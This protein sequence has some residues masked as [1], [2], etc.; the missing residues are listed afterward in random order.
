MS[1]DDPEVTW[2][3][4]IDESI[5]ATR[6]V[7]EGGDTLGMPGII[8]LQESGLRISPR[9]AAQ[10]ATL[11]RSVLT[12]LFCFGAML[13]SPKSTMKSAL[14]TTQSAAHQFQAVNKNFDT[15]CNDMLHRV[16]S[17]AKEANESYTFKE[18]LQQDDWNQFV[19]A[20]TKEIGDH[21]KRKH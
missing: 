18:M 1:A 4:V 13:I 2:G 8:N 21:T 9:I 16:F 17:V 5:P 20:M 12:T 14:T 11:Q 19:E 3:S 10:R 15:T 7:S 6:K